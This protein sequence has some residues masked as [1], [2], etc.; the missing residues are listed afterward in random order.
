MISYIEQKDLECAISKYSACLGLLIAHFG[1]VFVFF[2]L[3]NLITKYTKSHVLQFLTLII[4][5]KVYLK[6]KIFPSDEV[7]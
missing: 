3:S 5:A 1:S 7:N 6:Q 4:I 2:C